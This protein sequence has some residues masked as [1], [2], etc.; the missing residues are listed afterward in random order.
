MGAGTG[1][2]SELGCHVSSSGL[3]EA[4]VPRYPCYLREHVLLPCAHVEGLFCLLMAGFSPRP[5][6]E[7]LFFSRSCCA[8]VSWGC[9]AGRTLA[10]SRHG[11][12]LDVPAAVDPIFWLVT[13]MVLKTS[14]IFW[15]CQSVRRF[16][17]RTEVRMTLLLMGKKKHTVFCGSRHEMLVG[18]ATVVRFG[19]L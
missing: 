18:K 2:R 16:A 13:E 4:Y 10:P 14:F 8:L 15:P 17:A 7:Q 3:V 6:P 1:S 12:S 11:S 9:S 5:L 19:N